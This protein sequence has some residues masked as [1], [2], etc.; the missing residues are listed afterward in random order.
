MY[1]IQKDSTKI[2]PS[3]GIMPT[4]VTTLPKLSADGSVVK[5]ASYIAGASDALLTDGG[6]H[7]GS[8]GN[9]GG[10]APA[11]LTPTLT[12]RLLYG[13]KSWT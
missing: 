11:A 8:T 10:P 13:R 3:K 6:L 12:E 7:T 5:Q 2:D 4:P 9:T 1:G